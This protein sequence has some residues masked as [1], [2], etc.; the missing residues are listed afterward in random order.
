MSKL[1]DNIGSTRSIKFLE[2]DKRDG[3]AGNVNIRNIWAVRDLSDI[4]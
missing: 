2:I 1:V 3:I 4:A